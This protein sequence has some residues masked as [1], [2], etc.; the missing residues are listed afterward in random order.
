MFRA[1]QRGIGVG[2]QRHRS[3]A[4]TRVERDADA[5]VDLQRMAVDV[6]R[7]AKGVAHPAGQQLCASGQ[8]QLLYRGNE[9]V[10][11]DTRDIGS[12]GSLSQ[13]A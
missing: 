13:A 7:T 2:E 3:L 10:T 5:E 1:V 6:D 12:L 11:A 8:R 4:V 9:F